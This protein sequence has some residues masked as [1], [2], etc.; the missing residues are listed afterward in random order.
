ME[1]KM[2]KR[3]DVDKKLTWDLT[4]LLK[5]EK[6]FKA[7]FDKFISMGDGIERDYKGMLSN[8][9]EIN[10]CLDKMR[11]LEM[12][13]GWLENYSYLSAEVDLTNMKAQERL[14]EISNKISSMESRLSFVESEIMEA[15]EEVLAE[16]AHANPDNMGYFKHILIKKPFKLHPEVERV[17]AALSTTFEAPYRVYNMAKL[18]DLSFEDFQAKGKNHSLSFT[19]FEGQWEY[20]KDT[21]IRREAFKAFSNGLSKYRNTMATAYQ[22][23][24]TREKTLSDLRGFDSV[25]D[26]LLVDQEVTKELYNRQIDLVMEH[27]APHMRKYARLLGR[28]HGIE[29]M[30]FVDLKVDVDPDF[31][32]E[33]TIEETKKY[34]FEGLGILGEDYQRMLGRAFDERWID[35]VINEGKSTGAFCSTPYGAHPFVLLSWT[36]KM[37]DVFTLA[38]ELGHAGH[39]HLTHR[40]QSIYNS[41]PSLYF[42]EAPSTMN[43]MLLTNHLMKT[44][45]DKRMKR[46]VLSSIVSKT[47][48]HNFVTH[49]L[50]AHYQRE[51]YK[52]IDGGGSVNA[53]VLDDLKRK[54]LEIFWGDDVEIS[55]GAE[56]TWMRQPHYYMGLYPYTYSAGLTIATE[57]SQRILREG[58]TAIEDWRNVLIAGGTKNPVE[59]ARL[60]G[61]DITTEKP[62]MNTIAHIG[63]LIDEIEKLTDEM[64]SEKQ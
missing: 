35:F 51:V 41:E 40:N 57:A 59:L 15:P 33:V 42:I 24:V 52:I 60:A 62:L 48:Y 6:S 3:S 9:Q 7:T 37:R 64:E 58:D 4:G 12:L 1:D 56:L 34:I 13:G 43:E 17:L 10:H 45:D 32:P 47:Y 14:E 36:E 23:H 11:E 27:L 22:S 30:T 31:E 44:T 19:T 20:E 55:E 25:F 50:E 53:E 61:V 5:D 29:K 18:A 2:P 28:I 39:F 54:T 49:L 38:H 63:K 26:S 21:D 46:W 8:A 16:A